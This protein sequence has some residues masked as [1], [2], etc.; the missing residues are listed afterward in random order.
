MKVLFK[1]R[2]VQKLLNNFQQ[3]IKVRIAVYD[4]NFN[5]LFSSPKSFSSFCQKVRTNENINKACQHCDKK[6]FLQANVIKDTY[7]YK[8]HLGLYESVTPIIDRK[9]IL[10]YVMIGQILNKI[11]KEAQWNSLGIQYPDIVNFDTLKKDYFNLK[12]MNMTEIEAASRIM[13]ACASS[14]WLQY[15]INIERSPMTEHI[16]TYIKSHYKERITTE[17][18][19]NELNTSKTTIY[20]YLKAEYNLSLSQYI[21]YIRLE[22]AKKLLKENKKRIVSI[23]YDVGFEDYNYFSRKFKVAYGLTPSQFRKTK[24]L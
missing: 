14:I 9:Q 7:I 23:A 22:E 2:E 19:C 24:L 18:I 15:I 21:N 10:G 1:D 5:E 20:N 13:K 8:C 4:I 6:A 16:I 3:L 17:Q 11:N 12:Q